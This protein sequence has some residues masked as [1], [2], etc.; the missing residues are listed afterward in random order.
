LPRPSKNM[1]FRYQRGAEFALPQGDETLREGPRPSDLASLIAEHAH[2]TKSSPKSTS[3]VVEITRPLYPTAASLSSAELQYDD[4]LVPV[5]PLWR[6]WWREILFTILSF[7]VFSAIVVVLAA[8]DQQDLPDW[9]LN[10]TLNTFLAFFTTLARAAFMFPV[11]IAI[12]QTQWT[13]FLRERPLYDFHVLDQSSRGPWGSLVLLWRV[14]FKHI[15][16]LGAFLTVV[17]ILTSPISQLAIRYPVRDVVVLGEE[18]TTKAVRSIVS[19]RDDVS[20]GTAKALAIANVEDATNYT[21]PVS[22]RGAL[23]STGNCTFDPFQSL[24]MCVKLANITSFLRIEEYE[25]PPVDNMLLT[26]WD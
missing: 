12:S 11:S 16:S 3:H 2:F 1:A 26:G 23:C 20:P 18:A 22:P 14:R 24:G 19:P 8:F 21:S 5:K 4:R 13:W 9:P 6:V 7:A 10:I 15:I 25:E 17:S